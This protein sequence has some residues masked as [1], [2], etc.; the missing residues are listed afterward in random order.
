MGKEGS[1]EQIYV[2]LL[3]LAGEPASRGLKYGLVFIELLAYLLAFHQGLQIQGHTILW[4][5]LER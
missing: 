2:E 1:L 3:C 5:T 4:Q